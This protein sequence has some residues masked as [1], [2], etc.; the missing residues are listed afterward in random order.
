M[1]YVAV[2]NNERPAQIVR[3][4]IYPSSKIKMHRTIRMGTPREVGQNKAD[5]DD[6]PHQRNDIRR[7]R[8]TDRRKD[9]KVYTVSG[10]HSQE[11]AIEPICPV[12]VIYRISLHLF[13]QDSDCIWLVRGVEHLPDSYQALTDSGAV[14]PSEDGSERIAHYQSMPHKAG[15]RHCL[16]EQPFFAIFRRFSRFSQGLLRLDLVADRPRPVSAKVR[17]CGLRCRKDR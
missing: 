17:D 6:R 12:E 2:R 9:G 1:V 13:Q 8:I 10:Y 3:V 11:L 4:N 14:K 16:S 5:G 15:N 7:K